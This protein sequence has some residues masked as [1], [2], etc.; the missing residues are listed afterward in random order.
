[1]A[2]LVVNSKNYTKTGN[3]N[4]GKPFGT[5]PLLCGYQ[6]TGQTELPVYLDEISKIDIGFIPL[7][8]DEYQEKACILSARNASGNGNEFCINTYETN[9]WALYVKNVNENRNAFE[10]SFTNSYYELSINFSQ[11]YVKF[12]RQDLIFP[13]L[14]TVDYGFSHV[15]LI[16]NRYGNCQIAYI[17]VYDLNNDL[18]LDLLPQKEN[19]EFGAYMLDLISNTK[20]YSNTTVPFS[21][22]EMVDRDY[23]EEK[24][25][26]IFVETELGSRPDSG[27]TITLSEDYHNFDLLRIE[28][29]DSNWIGFDTESYYVTPTV[30]ERLIA[31]SGSYN[32]ICLNYGVSNHYVT[33]RPTAGTQMNIL[34]EARGAYFWKIYG[35]NCQ[36]YDFNNTMIYDAST[37]GATRTIVT[38]ENLNEFDLMLVTI[39]DSRDEMLPVLHLINPKK[40]IYEGNIQYGEY[41]VGLSQFF[42]DKHKMWNTDFN[43]VE[44][45]K[46]L[47]KTNT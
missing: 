31:K 20:F 16:L 44:G 42:I 15:P 17:K 23:K 11:S 27:S 34:S 46:L 28:I 12:M 36:N 14:H 45:I 1:M 4:I 10:L 8:T 43:V 41:Y 19:D 24:E 39:D 7:N 13:L 6:Y 30:L 40:T 38:D 33:L 5:V 29:K 21:Y 9:T 25:A 35:L 18:V 32:Q 22:R 2:N 26:P 37:S 47:P 3:I